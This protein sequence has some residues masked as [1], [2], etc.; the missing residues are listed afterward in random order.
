MEGNGNRVHRN[1][2]SG[3][4]KSHSWSS[5]VQSAA[6]LHRTLLHMASV[7]LATNEHSELLPINRVICVTIH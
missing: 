1:A 5:L 4:V 2:R 3:N 6:L 7:E